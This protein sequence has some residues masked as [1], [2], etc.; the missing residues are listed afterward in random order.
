MEQ[1]LEAEA[2]ME[3][4]PG[5]EE[6]KEDRVTD[7]D[8]ESDTDPKAPFSPQTPDS[9]TESEHGS[10]EAPPLARELAL[11]RDPDPEHDAR[12]IKYLGHDK[13]SYT[14]NE[15]ASHAATYNLHYVGKI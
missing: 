11:I 15:Y 13:A 1:L 3:N 2:S 5:E 6:L 4:H 9:K 10:P 12:F 7:D 14:K 8:F